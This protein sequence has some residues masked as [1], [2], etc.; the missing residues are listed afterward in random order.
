VP[1]LT[2]GKSFILGYTDES[3]NIYSNLPVVI[4]DDFTTDSK[5]VDFPF[6]V[7]SSAMKFLKVRES[8]NADLKFLYEKLNL[9]KLGST[10][11]DHKRRWISEFSKIKII[12]PKANLE[13]KYISNIL[14][15]VDAAIAQVEV[16]IAKYSRIKTGSMQDFLTKG[17]DKEGNIRSEETHDFKAGPF[18]LI[19][20]EWGVE[21]L[22]V[23][24]K[25]TSGLTLGKNYP[26]AGTKEF[27]YLR[28]ANVQDGFLDLDEIKYIRIPIAHADKYRLQDGDVLMNEGGDFDKLGRGT[29]WKGQI[30]ECLHQNHVF[31]VRTNKAKLLPEYLALYST[32]HHGKSFFLLSSKQSTNLAS[33]NKTQLKGFPILLPD[34][35]EQER[36]VVAVEKI[37]NVLNAFQEKLAKLNALRKGLVEDLLTGKVDVTKL[38][39]K[40]ETIAKT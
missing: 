1:V 7:K 34:T 32:S 35:D 25:I 40:T 24:A 13:Q 22:T 9:N 4:F 31:K 27:P 36:I 6:K 23:V 15:Q 10:G 30:E 12:V 18:G 39:K 28:V 8:S 11:G 38:I 29:V 2:A 17:I 37:S 21:K 5:F 20:V 33:I 14:S 16:L 19:P 3:E 26:E